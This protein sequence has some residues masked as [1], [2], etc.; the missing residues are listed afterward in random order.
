MG[1]QGDVRPGTTDRAVATMLRCVH[2]AAFPI[3]SMGRVLV[4][5]LE[6][7]S[8]NMSH[9][10]ERNAARFRALHEQ[11]GVGRSLTVG[12]CPSRG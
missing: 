1:A 4:D 3:V 11:D 2:Q 12:V 7:S 5:S 9:A 8:F 10:I 6:G